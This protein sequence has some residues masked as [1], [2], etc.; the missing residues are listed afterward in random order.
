MRNFTF[1]MIVPLIPI[2]LFIALRILE[3]RRKRIAQQGN[4]ELAA[5]VA[6][7]L[8]GPEPLVTLI[9]MDREDA[10]QKRPPVLEIKARKQEPASTADTITGKGGGNLS[11]NLARLSPL[12]QAVIWAEILGPPRG[13]RDSSGAHLEDA[14]SGI[15]DTNQPS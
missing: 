15:N 8:K 6:S 4:R 10:P 2:A 3:A 11:D 7:K 14:A 5:L 13:F 9:E 1:E 12:K